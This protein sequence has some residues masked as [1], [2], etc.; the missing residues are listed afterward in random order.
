MD[1]T[2]TAVTV[3]T[4]TASSFT[5]VKATASYIKKK[6]VKN[7]IINKVKKKKTVT[8]FNPLPKMLTSL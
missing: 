8:V 4:V 7:L 1:R 5:V 2:E 6:R 3:V